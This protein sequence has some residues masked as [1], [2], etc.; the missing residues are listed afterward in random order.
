MIS[1]SSLTPSEDEIVNARR[2]LRDEFA[3]SMIYGDLIEALAN[4]LSDIEEN[5]LLQRIKNVRAAVNAGQKI[6]P[7]DALFIAGFAAAAFDAHVRTW[8]EP[9]VDD[10]ISNFAAG[11]AEELRESGCI[12]N[13]Y[14]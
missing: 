13:H 1:L 12:V 14:A 2:V 11:K 7:V 8:A 6:S 3:E 4:S 10:F 9:Q 5:I